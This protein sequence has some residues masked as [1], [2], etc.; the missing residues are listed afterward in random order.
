MGLIQRVFVF[1]IMGH[2]VGC[3]QFLIARIGMF[4]SRSW[5]VRAGM[6]QAG[7]VDAIALDSGAP[8]DNDT[9]PAPI[10]DGARPAAEADPASCQPQYDIASLYIRCFY[11]AVVQMITATGSIAPE[12]TEEFWFS[13][14]VMMI[15]TYLFAD[16]VSSIAA[17][18]SVSE[19]RRQYQQ[20]IDLARAFMQHKQ[21]PF[22]L[23]NKIFAY[24]ALRNPGSL[25]FDESDF[26]SSL[27][28]PLRRELLK[29]TCGPVFVS[30][31]L[32]PSRIDFSLQ[33]ALCDSLQFVCFVFRDVII[34]QGEPD[35]PGL[36]VI[37]AG[38]C[39]VLVKQRSA[40]PVKKPSLKRLPSSK[41][42][43]EP[44][45]SPR[46]DADEAAGLASTHD[47]LLKVATLSAG[48]MFGEM[49]LLSHD[50]RAKA[51]VRCSSFFEGYLLSRQGYV[52][53]I[54]LYPSFEAHMQALGAQRLGQS[55]R[56]A[57][58]NVKR[59]QGPASGSGSSADGSSDGTK[60]HRGWLTARLRQIRSRLEPGAA[61]RQAA[62]DIHEMSSDAEARMARRH[63]E[64]RTVE[65]HA[66][67][68]RSS[69]GSQ[70][71][72]S[73]GAA[74]ASRPRTK[75]MVE[76]NVWRQQSFGN[77][78]KIVAA[79]AASDKQAGQIR[80]KGSDDRV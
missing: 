65:A 62:G 17:T 2:T 24:Y 8:A 69:R 27:S 71:R 19:A 45:S 43:V 39:E 67:A 49:S 59:D 58:F 37:S 29:H 56:F 57:A 79:S 61:D 35:V 26:L 52:Q 38:S 21:V 77:L 60:Q 44:A 32:N 7:C 55:R 33:A 50:I 41:D 64:R 11:H 36:Y 40:A 70:R 42:S 14:P 25:Y 53:L 73:S 15:G 23:R 1:I 4:D 47:N 6:V 18:V 80:Q 75:S 22:G 34:C 20:R 30:L 66:C 78:T 76:A 31:G 63:L 5:V 46:V 12:L 54:R 48:D 9:S 13:I 51:T 10:P 72:S 3:I 68:E 16:L 74:Q 28:A